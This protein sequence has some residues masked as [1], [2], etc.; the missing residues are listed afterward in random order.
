[1]L[2]NLFHI[3]DCFKKTLNLFISIIFLK[4][5]Y[6]IRNSVSYSNY[7][8][9]HFPLRSCDIEK[10]IKLKNYSKFSMNHEHFSLKPFQSIKHSK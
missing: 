5:K 7:S 9:F 4:I 8:M 6:K 3:P 1:M 10:I 2:G